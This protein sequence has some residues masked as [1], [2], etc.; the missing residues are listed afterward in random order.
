MIT[1]RPAIEP[2]HP[3]AFLTEEPTDLIEKGQV[4][5]VPWLTGLNSHEGSL[6]VITLFSNNERDSLTKLNEKWTK[7]APV[8]LIIDDNCPKNLQDKVT[9]KIR[10]F[11]FGNEDITR[12]TK[13]ELT[14]ASDKY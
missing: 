1:F 11:Y 12:S 2:D 5:D 14:N 13:T 9:N 10:K 7:Y 8:S 6:R 4:N 3:G